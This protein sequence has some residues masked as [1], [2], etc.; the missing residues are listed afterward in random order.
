[1]VILIRT[2]A[3]LSLGPEARSPLGWSHLKVFF[4]EL[5]LAGQSHPALALAESILNDFRVEGLEVFNKFA[6]FARR[7]RGRSGM[8]LDRVDS[9][10][11]GMGGGCGAFVF[12]FRSVQS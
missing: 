9:L 10:G 12:V 4:V 11:R 1:M 8:G 3:L 6:E 5:K 7:W 2:H